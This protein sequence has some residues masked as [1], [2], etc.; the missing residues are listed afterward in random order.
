MFFKEIEPK[1]RGLITKGI[2]DAF[3]RSI[4]Y[5]ECLQKTRIEIP[6]KNKDGS[7]SKRPSVFYKCNSCKEL[8]NSSN[9]H[10]DHITPVVPLKSSLSEMDLNKYAFNVNNLSIQVLCKP[11]HKLKTKQENAK[12]VGYR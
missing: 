3:S 6:K 5:K 10:V 12:R 1:L 7:T 4:K 8:V 11:C 2:R 9:Y